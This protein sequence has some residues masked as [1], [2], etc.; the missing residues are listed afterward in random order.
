MR[1]GDPVLPLPLSPP[2]VPLPTCSPTLRAPTLKTRDSSDYGWYQGS[3][4]SGRCTE[5]VAIKT[6]KVPPVF[7]TMV[8]KGGDNRDKGFG[9]GPQRAWG[10]KTFCGL[11]IPQGA[12][13]GRRWADVSTEQ[14]V[15]CRKGSGSSTLEALSDRWKVFQ[16]RSRTEE[17][18][19]TNKFSRAP[20][21]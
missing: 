14:G 4:P 7:L 18:S 15:S 17:D 6:R 8:D 16:L 19:R 21:P 2:L 20:P 11:T 9:S 10:D 5:E 13:L 3:A 1:T 12:V